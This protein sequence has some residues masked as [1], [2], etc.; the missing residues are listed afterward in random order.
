MPVSCK[1]EERS[2]AVRLMVLGKN[3]MQRGAP[4]NVTLAVLLASLLMYREVISAE[5]II[6]LTMVGAWP[7][8]VSPAADVGVRSMV[9]VNRRARGRIVID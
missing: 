2:L 8:V 9:E 4:F 7:P 3:I 6:E 5:S 1:R